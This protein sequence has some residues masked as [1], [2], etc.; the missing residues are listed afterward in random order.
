[1]ALAMNQNWFALLLMV[2]T[3]FPLK[4]DEALDRAL[5]GAAEQGDATKVQQLL[6]QGADHKYVETVPGSLQRDGDSPLYAATLK[7]S[8]DCVKRSSPII[9]IKT[10]DVR[11][12]CRILQQC[13]ERA[14]GGVTPGHSQRSPCP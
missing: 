3:S 2:I 12:G 14:I 4:A 7:Q 6:N 9:Q 10:L 11:V 13:H 1:M 5:L 8:T